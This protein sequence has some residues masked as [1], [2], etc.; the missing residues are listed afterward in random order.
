MTREQ[1]AEARVSARTWTGFLA[2]CLGMFM[3]VLDIQ[4]VA[5][6]LPEIQ[7]AVRIPSHELSWV[8]TGYLIAEV[9]AIPLT[10]WLTRLMTLRG[11]FVIAAAGFTAASVGCAMSDSFATL[12][13]FRVV[14]G[15]CGGAII[16][17]VFTSVFMLFPKARQVRATAVAG[18]FAVLAPTLGPVVGGYITETYSWHWLFLINLAPGIV[19]TLLVGCLLRT[20]K[21][22]WSLLGSFDLASLA[23][24]A[25]CLASLEIMLKEAPPRGWTSPLIL[26]LLALTLGTAAVLIPRSL[27]R[28]RPLIVL[29][30]FRERAFA[31]GCVYS[32]IL[33]AGLYG[34]VYLLPIFL[35]YIRE[36]TPLEI[37]LIMLVGGVT[38]LIIAPISAPLER[39][40][41]RRLLTG[42][43]Y[44]VFAAGLIA[45]GFATFETDYD[46]L[47][48]PQVLRGFAVMFCL[49][50]TT[51]LALEGQSNASI[52]DAS[53]FFNLMRN[54]GGAIGIALI[55]TVLELRPATHAAAI[56]ERL[57][58]GDPVTAAFVGLPLDRFHNVPL[59]PIDEA[60]KETVRPLVERAA[61]VASFNDAYFLL[62]GLFLLSLVLLPLLRPTPAPPESVEP[63]SGI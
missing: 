43:G 42:L 50:P 36:H 30:C 12:V 29:H 35:G 33:G 63:I 46:G 14:Q 24:L 34:S 10:G 52:A 48:W 3:A 6:S 61:A 31:V 1:S 28:V 54:L 53:G 23:L 16:P 37:G 22:D 39:R 11:M 8:Q 60:T 5:S 55:D 51:S 41:D 17:A 62:G 58:A 47:F 21:P 4:I 7:A 2:M 45:N 9:I 57:Q 26:A 25:I 20:G 27:R 15:F 56:V 19:V 18:V 32:F 40:V 38:Q 49:L 59:G 44:G 13:T